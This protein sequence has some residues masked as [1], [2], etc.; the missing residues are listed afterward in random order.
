[1][2]APTRGGGI[3]RDDI[4]SVVIYAAWFSRNQFCAA[5]ARSIS[6]RGARDHKTVDEE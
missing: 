1:V 3:G 2:S 5:P 6:P 4:T